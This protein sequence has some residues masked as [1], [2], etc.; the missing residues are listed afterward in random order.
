MQ[1]SFLLFQQQRDE[2]KLNRESLKKMQNE[3]KRKKEKK[4]RKIHSR[5]RDFCK[6]L[7]EIRNLKKYFWILMRRFIAILF[8]KYLHYFDQ[9]TIFEN[10]FFAI[11]YMHEFWNKFHSKNIWVL[12][13]LW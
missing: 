4:K 11:A 2:K 3:K 7:N 8:V 10:C 13:I 5:R 6:F 9:N 12:R 1:N